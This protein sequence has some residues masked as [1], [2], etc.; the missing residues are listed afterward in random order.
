MNRPLVTALFVLVLV[1]P[2]VLWIWVPAPTIEL[3]YLAAHAGEVRLVW[4]FLLLVALVSAW[5]GARR[6]GA[7]RSAARCIGV[8]AFAGVVATSV[9]E[10]RSIRS[11]AARGV[12]LSLRRYALAWATDDGAPRS[13][14][15][16]ARVEGE[17]LLADVWDARDAPTAGELAPA[18][19]RVHGGSWAFGSRSE[20]PHWCRALTEAG[21]VVFD[22][23]YRLT[24]PPRF[25]DAVCDVRGAV[26][27]VREHAARFGVDAGRIGLMGASAGGHLALSA[28]YGDDATFPPTPAYG[29]DTPDA[30]VVSVVA[31]APPVVLDIGF[32]AT[33]PWWYP[34][35]LRSTRRVEELVGG[36]PAEVP[37]RYR[38]ASPIEHVDANSP[39]TLLV[40]G[41][42]DR[43]VWPANCERLGARLAAHGVDYR[44]VELPGSDHLFEYAPGGWSTQVA[45]WEVLAFLRESPGFA[46]AHESG[47]R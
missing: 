46:P 11:A 10:V 47:V 30:R 19:V 18:I 16:F 42:H 8:L 41:A 29:V 45:E 22:V 5:R 43:L 6:A 34:D 23:D 33:Y 25:V 3:W 36:T 14:L 35:D 27:W 44:Y 9:A 2:W 32:A 4:V 12:D 31:I 21:F 28:A 40:H 24:P 38:V 7:N 15:P 17:E 1:A 26:S 39:R 13:T 37:Q 20:S